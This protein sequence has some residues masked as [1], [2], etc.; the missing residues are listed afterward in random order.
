MLTIPSQQGIF[1]R[2]DPENKINKFTVTSR[3]ISFHPSSNKTP[4]SPPYSIDNKRKPA[5]EE[6]YNEE[7]PAGIGEDYFYS[8]L[9][10]DDDSKMGEVSGGNFSL[11]NHTLFQQYYDS[12]NGY[13]IS[14]CV[15]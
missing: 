3:G 1:G 7:L 4:S 15:F 8:P 11:K 6:K 10:I 12:N 13:V 5:P 9:F 14:R 2:R